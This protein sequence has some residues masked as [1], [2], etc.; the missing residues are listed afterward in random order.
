MEPGPQ[1]SGFNPND[2]AGVLALAAVTLI[3]LGLDKN[4]RRG[5]KILL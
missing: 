5:N 2:V 1:P 4:T 3:G